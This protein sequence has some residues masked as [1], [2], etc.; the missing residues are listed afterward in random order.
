MA[1]NHSMVGGKGF[2]THTMIRDVGQ[3]PA[4]SKMYCIPELTFI[5]M[6]TLIM[7]GRTV[8]H[9]EEP[10]SLFKSMAL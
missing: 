6:E 10:F 9:D 2:T 7:K 8:N 3:S 1:A 5:Q 4:I